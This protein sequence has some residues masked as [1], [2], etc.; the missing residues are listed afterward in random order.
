MYSKW[1]ATF[2]EA[3][4][5]TICRD[6]QGIPISVVTSGPPPSP[7]PYIQPWDRVLAVGVRQLDGPNREGVL[8]GA[9]ERVQRAE[10]SN[11]E[12]SSMIFGEPKPSKLPK[13]TF[14]STEGIKTSNQYQPNFKG[15]KTKTK[16]QPKYPNICS[17][18]IPGRTSYTGVET[19][20]RQANLDKEMA[21]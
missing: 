1:K 6:S 19:D 2:L 5:T 10:L 13:F 3:D 14:M 15:S 4:F 8:D 9:L 11:F 20:R 18:N 21:E 7:G 12:N 16:M 17:N